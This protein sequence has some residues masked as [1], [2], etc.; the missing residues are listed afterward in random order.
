MTMTDT[1]LLALIERAAAEHWTKL[2]LSDRGLTALPPEI[3]RLRQLKVLILGK[4]DRE[5]EEYQGN[6][7]AALPEEI[8]Q[9]QNL[10]ALYL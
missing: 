7:I 6:A 9:L 8:G 2:D 10:T 5:E 4:W 1:E 3:G